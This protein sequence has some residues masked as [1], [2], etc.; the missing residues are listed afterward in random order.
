MLN[1]FQITSQFNVSFGDLDVCNTTGNLFVASS[2]ESRLAEFTP[3]GAFVEYHPLPQ[4]VGSLSGL[5]LNCET[6]EAWVGG[7]GGT[8]WRLA[9]DALPVELV[10]FRALADGARALLEWTTASETRNAGFFVEG[11]RRRVAAGDQG[12]ENRPGGWT[13]LGFV[14]GAGT[15]ATAASYRF[16]TPPLPSGRHAFRLRQADLDGT[17]TILET[18]DVTIQPTSLHQLTL[19]PSPATDRVTAE[20]IV[21]D[22][23]HVSITIYDLLGREVAVLFEGQVSA[24]TPIRP[25]LDVASRGLSS[26]VYFVRAVGE[27]FAGTERFVVAR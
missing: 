7:T 9:G 5:G 1:V 10:S 3:D 2:V 20:L 11:L 13:E 24:G 16:A 12:Q 6:G 21:R 18:V 4:G 27:T 22:A 25:H 23:Q 14:R 26:G 8:V 15:T 17:E 19:Y